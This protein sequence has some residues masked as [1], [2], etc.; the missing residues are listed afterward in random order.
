LDINPEVLAG[1]I[2]SSLA[3]AHKDVARLTAFPVVAQKRTMELVRANDAA[4]LTQFARETAAIARDFADE[5]PALFLDAFKDERE[6]M[7]IYAKRN[8]LDSGFQELLG[9]SAAT[10]IEYDAVYKA[11]YLG[12]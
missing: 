5:R 2:K 3:I 11:K 12:A 4:G 7:R 9:V 1:A 6:H 10:P 8:Q